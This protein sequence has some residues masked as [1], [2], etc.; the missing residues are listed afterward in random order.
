MATQSL[1]MNE[2]FL[3]TAFA[4][5]LSV[6][7]DEYHERAVELAEQL[8][9]RKTK[10]ITTRAVLLEIGNALSRRRYRDSAVKLLEALEIDPNV[11][12][13]PLTDELYEHAFDL[14]RSRPDKEWRMID[15]MSFVVMEQRGLNEAL[16]ADEHFQQAGFRAVLRR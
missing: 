11:E 3:D 15:C 14:F 10:L 12:C 9:A 5:A 13:V 4:I 16:T 6:R 7:N 2:V 8:E 1:A